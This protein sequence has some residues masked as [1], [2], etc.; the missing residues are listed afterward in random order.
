[1]AKPLDRILREREVLDVI[2]ISR[3]QLWNLL[4]DGR[5]PARVRLAGRSMGWRQSDVQAWIAS[6]ET[7]SA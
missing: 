4:K 5:F 1:M 3:S 7:V 6:R 2:G